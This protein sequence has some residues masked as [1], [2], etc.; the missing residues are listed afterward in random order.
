MN[1]SLGI[2]HVAYSFVLA[3]RVELELERRTRRGLSR[4]RAG[5]SRA[6]AS[7]I[8]KS[9]GWSWCRILAKRSNETLNLDFIKADCSGIKSVIGSMID[10]CLGLSRGVS[11][12]RL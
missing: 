2:G 6:P 4:D 11:Y 8:V 1:V 5:E 3:P 9:S 10:E 12:K 7:I